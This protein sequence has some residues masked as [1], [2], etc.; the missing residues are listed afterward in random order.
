MTAIGAGRARRAGQP[1]RLVINVSSPF[2]LDY[3]V[4]ALRRRGTT[5][6]T[7]S[8]QGVTGGAGLAW[9]A[10]E[11]TVRQDLAASTPKLIAELRGPRGR[12][13]APPLPRP[14]RSWH[15]YW[16]SMRALPGF[17]GSPPAM[18]G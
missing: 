10:A 17:T 14:A 16:A 4:W 8:T 6:W 2:R 1:A 5:R 7:A 18:P 9:R 13:A 3:V 15:A 12:L 11:V